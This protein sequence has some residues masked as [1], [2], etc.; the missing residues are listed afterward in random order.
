LPRLFIT[1]DVPDAGKGYLRGTSPQSINPVSVIT[2]FY[3]S[4]D[5]ASIVNQG[6]VRS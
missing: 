5:D 6:F 3:S 4:D 1:F 2:G